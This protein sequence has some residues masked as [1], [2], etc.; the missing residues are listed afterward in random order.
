MPGHTDEWF[1]ACFMGA[2]P[3]A[4]ADAAK[5]IGNAPVTFSRATGQQ[6]LPSSA[7][8]IREVIAS[9]I[10]EGARRVRENNSTIGT[11]VVG[12]LV[13]T[14]VATATLAVVSIMRD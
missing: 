1:A 12:A 13:I 8:Q 11:I 10:A 9:G 3:R 7:D 14:A 6:A 4:I 5:G 2:D